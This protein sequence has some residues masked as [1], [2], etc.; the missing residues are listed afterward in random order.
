MPCPRILQFTDTLGDVNGVSR[1]IRNLADAALEPSPHPQPPPH[2]TVFCSTRF[3]I[4]VQPNIINFPPRAAMKIPR[5]ENL[6]LVWPPEIQM[7]AAARA[8]RPD[9]IHISTPGPVGCIGWLAA[10]ILGVPRAGVYHTDFPAYIEKL[11]A[12]PSMTWLC[13]AFMQGFY[14][15]F[16]RIFTRSADYRDRLAALGIPPQRLLPLRP[17]IRIDEFGPHF[18]DPRIWSSRASGTPPPSPTAATPPLRILYCGRVSVEKNMPLLARVW[19]RVVARLAPT[20]PPAELV[21]VGDGPYRGEMERELRSLP[22]RFLGFRYGP[23]LSA[24]YASSDIFVFPSLTDTLGQV[25]MEAQASGLPVIVGDI[26]GPKEVVRHGETGLIVPGR[27]ES[28][29]TDAILALI[30]DEPRR[31]AMSISA[32]RYLQTFSFRASFDHFISAHA[33]LLARQPSPQSSPQPAPPNS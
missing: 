25:V 13:T 30:R 8:F 16:H 6:E 9:V 1:F 33:D 19:P 10:A 17:G 12:D 5:Y 23:E 3:P 28:A 21:I 31:R 4:P 26:G 22:V 18:R 20:A 11:F 14:S 15:R 24:I 7:L 2:L 32:H 27:D 29:W